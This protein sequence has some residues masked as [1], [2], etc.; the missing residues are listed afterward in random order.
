MADFYYLIKLVLI[1]N[2][3]DFRIAMAE[4]ILACLRAVG[5]VNSAGNHICHNCPMEGKGP[6]WTVVT[7]V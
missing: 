7:R 3:A 2:T 4:D 6:L 1:F 5:S